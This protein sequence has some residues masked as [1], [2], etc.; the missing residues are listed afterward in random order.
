MQSR[1]L[2]TIVQPVVEAMEFEFVGLEYASNPKNPVL[3]VYIDHPDGIHVEDCAAVSRE[4]AAILDVEDPIAGHYTLEVSS[5]G[6]DRPLFTQEQY[7]NFTGHQAQISLFAPE[8]GRRRFKGVILGAAD[9]QVQIE[10]DGEAVVL[11][12]SNIAKARLVP[13]FENIF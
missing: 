11:D 13:D 12:Y 4:V 10:Q 7:A 3:V 5:P 8:A 2:T 6:L 9:G 1:K